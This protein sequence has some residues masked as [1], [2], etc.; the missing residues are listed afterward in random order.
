MCTNTLPQLCDIQVNYPLG[1]FSSTRDYANLGHFC[2]QL[3]VVFTEHTVFN[4]PLLKSCS[5]RHET[6]Q[7]V[8]SHDR[9]AKL[10]G[11]SIFKNTVWP[12]YVLFIWGLAFW[13]ESK[14]A[15]LPIS[16]FGQINFCCTRGR[17]KISYRRPR[18]VCIVFLFTW[19]QQRKV[20]WGSE[21]H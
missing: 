19:R 13:K 6:W 8:N 2:V 12:W 20:I 15:Y 5:N 10:S 11:L 9:E 14:Q 18:T 1:L 16:S 4:C 21:G 7:R 3:F 17:K